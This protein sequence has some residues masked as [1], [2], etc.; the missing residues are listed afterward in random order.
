[1]FDYDIFTLADVAL[2]VTDGSAMW[3]LSPVAGHCV[4]LAGDFLPFSSDAWSIRQF[5]FIE[6]LFLRS[7]CF[8][9]AQLR[10]GQLVWTNWP[11]LVGKLARC[12]LADVWRLPL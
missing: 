8:H 10:G 5:P 1:V 6:A 9:V 11:S 3:L 12:Y 2:V 7:D 4:D